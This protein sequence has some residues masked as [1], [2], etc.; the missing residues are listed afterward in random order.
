[1]LAKKF[2]LPIGKW[3]KERSRK[4]I[5]KKGVFFIVKSAPNNLEFS[6]FGVITGSKTVKTAVRR[7]R[8]KRLI[9]NFIR[10]NEYF[11]PAGKDA[12][13][14]VQPAANK[15]KKPEMEKELETL[16]T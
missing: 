2:R 9:F 12:L 3:N 16:L 4:T 5:V 1:M 13:I 11:R 7:N 10:L 6:R 15:A 14:I 8:L